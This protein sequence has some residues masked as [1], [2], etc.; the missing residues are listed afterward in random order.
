MLFRGVS[1]VNLDAKGRMALPVRF[2]EVLS[3]ASAGRIVV[4]IDMEEPCLLLYPLPFWEEIQAQL[5]A[6]PNVNP[7]ARRVQRLLI[8]HATDAELDGSGRVL[9][10]PM[11]RDYA[12][13]SKKLVLLGQG[14]KLE[15]WSE[16][17]WTQRRDSWL[18]DGVSMADAS[19]ELQSIS[20]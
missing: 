8:G 7:A 10:P 17:I 14:R 18:D 12:S 13:L 15:I 16:E 20:L 4:T 19:A 2:R 3:E 1:T 5:E 11:L 6:L 9:L